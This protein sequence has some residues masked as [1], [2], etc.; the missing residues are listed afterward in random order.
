MYKHSSLVNHDKYFKKI[1]PDFEINPYFDAYDCIT[2][3]LTITIVDTSKKLNTTS[4]TVSRA[5]NNHPAISQET[6]K[7]VIRMAE[8]LNY[9]RNTVASSLRLGQTGIIGVTI[10]GAEIN[11]FGPVV[12]GIE[13][14][15]NENE[16]NV[17]IFQSNE[18][19]MHEQKGIETFLNARVDGILVSMAKETNDYKHF[20]AVKHIKTPI[21]FFDRASD[22]LEIDAVL[23]DDYKGAYLA[24]EHLI[25]Q[26]YKRIAHIS[27]PQY[28][29]IFR[30]RLE[31]YKA[32]LKSA[33]IRFDKKLVFAGD[34]SINAGRMAIKYFIFLENRPD[35]AFAVEDFTALGAIKELKEQ[36][37]NI[38]SEFGIIGF[39]NEG[40]GEHIT[41][42]LSTIDQQTVNMEKEAFSLM[43]NLIER[44]G[45]E[46]KIK[47]FKKKYSNLFR[48]LETL[49]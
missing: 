2:L 28:L 27:G 3:S 43:L 44:K 20:L 42:S 26:G 34:V 1:S 36:G 7:R 29:N 35:A 47:I 10:P 4:G 22:E 49:H 9:R 8:K 11:F 5:L 40:F 45:K 21:V 18:S 41:P 14:M 38:P 24:T 31:G 13:R 15:A 39:A 30:T 32:A 19:W 37:I 16:Y 48:F 17:L 33:D 25:Q 12:H 6:K 23:I 46:Q